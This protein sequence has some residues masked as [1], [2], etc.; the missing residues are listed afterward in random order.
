M[1]QTT[2]FLTWFIFFGLLQTVRGNN[3]TNLDELLQ[4]VQQER[5]NYQKVL[6]EREKKFLQEKKRQQRLLNQELATL[7]KLEAISKKLQG[8]FEKNEKELSVLEE[9]L[10]IATGT[11]GEMFGV[12]K[13]VA[14]DFKGQFQNSLVSAQHPKRDQFM[15]GIAERKKLPAL[16]DLNQLW[17]EIQKEMTESGKITRFKSPVVTSDGRKEERVVTRIGS[18]NLVANGKYLSYQSDTNQVMELPRQPRRK[19]LGM[20]EDLEELKTGYTPFGLDPTRGVI[21]G[22][23]IHAPGW[24]ER[25]QQGGIV[26]YVIVCLLFIGLIIVGERLLTLKKEGDKIKQQLAS[27]DIKTDNPIGLLM[28]VFNQYKNKDVQTLEMKLDE[29]VIKATPKLQQGISTIKILSAVAPLMG[30]LGTVTGMIAT[31]QS[32]TLYGT[33]DPK[34]MAGGISTALVTTVLGLVC[35][36]PLLLLHNFVSSKSN[37]LIH[38]LEEQ[39]AGL[40]SQKAEQQ[41]ALSL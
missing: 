29:T 1:K 5:M 9:K 16:K 7:K 28:Q 10:T 33:G 8:T 38:I 18:F 12:V 15:S 40:L 21:L 11:L 6:S 2:I 4:Q 34:L 26:G 30:L 32:I 19:F 39:V 41:G 35:A 22:K 37:R 3:P 31:F 20:I 13:Q 27:S 14:G 17:F 36:I 24:S 25:L 23:L